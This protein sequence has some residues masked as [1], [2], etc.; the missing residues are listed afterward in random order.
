MHAQQAPQ[1]L[2]QAARVRARNAFLAA[3]DTSLPLQ[4]GSAQH[5]QQE[6]SLA[7][8]LWR[9]ACARL[10]LLQMQEQSA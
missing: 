7:K 2:V 10:E 6:R 4:Q 9:A 3:Q 1:R 8:E 5:V